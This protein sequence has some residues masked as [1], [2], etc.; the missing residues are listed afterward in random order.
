MVVVGDAEAVAPAGEAVILIL[1][2]PPSAVIQPPPDPEGAAQ[3]V[4][5]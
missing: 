3:A 4:S 2:P 5:R 1:V